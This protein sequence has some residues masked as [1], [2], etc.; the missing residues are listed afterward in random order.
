MERLSAQMAADFTLYYSVVLA[1]ALNIFFFSRFA[2][3][4]YRREPSKT[5]ALLALAAVAVPAAAMAF[6]LPPRA[7]YDNNHDFLC[8]GSDF[9][10]TRPRMLLYF[11]EV[12]PLFTDA[13]SDLLS[14]YSLAGVLWKNRALRSFRGAAAPGRRPDGQRGRRGFLRAEFPGPAQRLGLRYHQLQRLHLAA[15]P[16]GRYRRLRRR[17]PRDRGAG[18]DDQFHGAGDQRPF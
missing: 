13:V 15:F 5:R 7:G 2:A 8:L 12:S 16:A 14:N 18:L 1:W 3:A 10:T 17:R 4:W 6:F 11:K 9:F